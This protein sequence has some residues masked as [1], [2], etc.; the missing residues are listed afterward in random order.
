MQTDKGVYFNKLKADDLSK[1][2]IN[3]VLE[4]MDKLRL[5]NSPIPSELKMK[6][7][8]DEKITEY[9]TK[10][11]LRLIEG[12]ISWEGLFVGF[13][14]T[15]SELST[16]S[17]GTPYLRKILYPILDLHHRLQTRYDKKLPCIYFVGD[18]FSDVFLRKFD[19]LKDVIPHIIV[20]TN[21]LYQ[22]YSNKSQLPLT[23][24]KDNFESWTNMKLCQCMDS[25]E[26]LLIPLKS[27]SINIK[28]L[29]NEVPCSEGTENPE[30]LDI[31]GYDK[32]TH[33]LVAFEIKGP[34]ISNTELEN[35]F[36]QGME[37]RNWL[38]KN[39]MAVK[40]LFDRGPKGKKINTKKRVRLL[41]GFYGEKVP[42]I[43]YELQNG[44]KK[45]DAY[46]EIDFVRI[47]KKD[48]GIIL[49]PFEES[50]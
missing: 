47:S 23:E 16:K 38:E 36:L 18:R 11:D 30:R 45:G 2:T 31:L 29:S 43:F 9:L 4:H 48:D 32:S 6:K 19:L 34:S 41:L 3:S 37:H 25:K 42:Q 5:S 28:Y 17:V 46:T 27:N 12:N 13:P 8:T 35:L 40:L 21:D 10:L 15:V 26:G 49:S 7:G 24:A 50:I 20:L 39:K 1:S 44:A 22:C 14:G 33:S